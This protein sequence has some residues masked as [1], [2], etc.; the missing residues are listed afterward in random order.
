MLLVR[1]ELAR[2]PHSGHGL[3]AGRPA[4][5]VAGGVVEADAAAGEGVETPGGGGGNEGKR[6]Q[7]AQWHRDID[8]FSGRTPKSL[9]SPN[10]PRRM[11]LQLQLGNRASM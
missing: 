7:D 8:A 11:M 9:N 2:A 1:V 6:K 10:E 4:V 3:V 5:V